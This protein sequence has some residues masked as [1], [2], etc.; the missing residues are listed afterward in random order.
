MHEQPGSTFW[1]FRDTDDT[2]EAN[3]YKTL[4]TNI[5][6]PIRA[7]Q[8]AIDLFRKEKKGGAVVLLSSIAAQ[9]PILPLPLYAASKAAIS[10]FARSMAELE[11]KYGIRVNAV[12]PGLVKT[13]IWPEDRVAWADE[14]VDV[15]IG[16]ERI[17]EV[18]LELIENQEYVGGT[19]LEVGCES[20]RKVAVLNDPGSGSEKG[21]TVANLARG[22][23]DT[24]E[25]IEEQFGRSN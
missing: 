1:R 11:P 22:Y 10:S 6:H 7:T 19:V 21:C 17:A 5:T 14:K 8:L 23:L 2:V 16:T 25:T 9:L 12:A 24:F 20:V 18:M 15:W 13:P 4:E 3:S